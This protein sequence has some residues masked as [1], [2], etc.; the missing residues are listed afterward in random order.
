MG[1]D[2]RLERKR[3]TVIDAA[4]AIKNLDEK[5]F[6]KILDSYERMYR[7]YVLRRGVAALEDLEIAET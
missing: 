1:A 2:T 4:V 5:E 3:Q 6:I 7:N